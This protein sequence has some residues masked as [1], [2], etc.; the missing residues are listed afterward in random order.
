MRIRIVTFGLNIPPEDYTAY[1]VHIAS[2]FTAWPGLLSKWWL[3]DTA[4][5]TFGG[6][7]LFAS[8][9]DADRSRQTDLFRGMF[10]NPALQNVSVWE[11]D[12]LDEPTAIT[13][14]PPYS[15][16]SGS[17]PPPELVPG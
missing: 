5:G 10:T 12:I 13:A 16:A 3:G 9:E 2:G 1:A 11:Y 17:S 14:L 6:V 7:Y 15:P 4:S 8:Q